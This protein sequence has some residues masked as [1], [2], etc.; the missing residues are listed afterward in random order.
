MS[1]KRE[2]KVRGGGL[3]SLTALHQSH[4][5]AGCMEGYPTS[6]RNADMI[7]STLRDLAKQ[8]WDETPYLIEP[9]ETPMKI[10]ISAEHDYGAPM[11]LPSILCIAQF[12]SFAPARDKHSDFSRL[13]VV[14][15]QDDFAFPIETEIEKHIKKIDWKNLAHDFGF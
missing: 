14:W 12:Q 1:E 11:Q 7:E 6:A 5:Y 15:F 10:E 9:R 8:N 2:F 13:T 4:T 3:I